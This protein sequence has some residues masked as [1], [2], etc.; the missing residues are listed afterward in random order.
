MPRHAG[1]SFERVQ[2]DAGTGIAAQQGGKGNVHVWYLA[3][4]TA[5]GAVMVAIVEG[6]AV[7]TMPATIL[8]HSVFEWSPS[9]ALGQRSARWRVALMSAVDRHLAQGVRSVSLMR[10][11]AVGPAFAPA[12]QLSLS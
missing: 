5:S 1:A 11:A 12:K 7:W 10:V 3:P 9:R 6:P 4:T 8:F 2:Q